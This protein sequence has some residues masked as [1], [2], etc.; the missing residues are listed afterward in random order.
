[1]IPPH[2]PLIALTATATP[3]VQA[4]IITN[5]GLR[6]P[7]IAK[8]TFDRP[9]LKYIVSERTGGSSGGSGDISSLLI[10]LTKIYKEDWWQPI[11]PFDIVATGKRSTLSQN[12]T[13]P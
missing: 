2:T 1:M 13:L 11:D 7:Y 4:D 8:T 9:N 6:D 10:L 12:L 5:L 3:V